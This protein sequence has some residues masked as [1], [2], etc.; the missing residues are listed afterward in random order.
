[1]RQIGTSIFFGAA[2][3]GLAPAV[4]KP[5]AEANFARADGRWGAELGIGYNF[6]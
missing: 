6:G 1:M 3:A 4:A 2:L 5:A